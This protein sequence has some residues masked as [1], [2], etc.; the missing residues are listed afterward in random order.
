MAIASIAVTLVLLAA[1]IT[2]FVENDPLFLTI[3]TGS[4][5]D[6]A[7]R[8][9]LQTRTGAG[10]LASYWHD[11]PLH[12]EHLDRTH[13]VPLVIEIPVGRL[14][15]MEINKATA[16]NPIVQD[17]KNGKLRNYPFANAAHYGA[18]PQTYEHP[19]MHDAL[20]HLDGDGDPVDALDISDA[21]AAIGDVVPLKVLGAIGMIDDGEID[22]KI[23]GIRTTDPLAEQLSDVARVMSCVHVGVDGSGHI[24]QSAG[25]E[26]VQAALSATERM[27]RERVL[28]IKQFFA[29]YKKPT[30][31]AVSTTTFAFDGLP[32]D[33]ASA[34]DVIRQ[35]HAQWCALFAAV[36]GRQQTPVHVARRCARLDAG[37]VAVHSGSDGAAA[38]AP[39]DLW[40]FPV[41]QDD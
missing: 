6:A 40:L 9:Q 5:G 11:I 30:P 20:T 16:Y 8:A 35:H 41:V 27:L 4:A 31:D 10:E 2:Q 29:D 26:P 34:R 17:V 18:L 39:S 13:V 15:K 33:A 32:L 24:Q 36:A 38:K 19:G 12:A 21:P 28:A 37:A 1:A 14:E 23:I 25:S 7:F 3:A 22:Y